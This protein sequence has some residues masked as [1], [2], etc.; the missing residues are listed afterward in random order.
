[1]IVFLLGLIDQY[2]A[3][4]TECCTFRT[5]NYYYLILFDILFLNILSWVLLVNDCLERRSLHIKAQ[6]DEHITFVSFWK[7]FLMPL[8]RLCLYGIFVIRAHSCFCDIHQRFI[9][10][11]IERD[12][13]ATIRGS[14]CGNFY[15]NKNVLIFFI[16]E[17]LFYVIFK[18]CPSL[19]KS[20]EFMTPGVLKYAYNSPAL[21]PPQLIT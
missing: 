9:V 11:V 19:L 5:G 21:K 18:S 14:Q 15:I 17:K 8:S 12:C 7:V 3:R 13:Y 1:M 16:N 2:T 4:T 20:P 6:L 10:T